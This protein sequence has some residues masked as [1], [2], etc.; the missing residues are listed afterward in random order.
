MK[1]SGALC[2]ALLFVTHPALYRAARVTMARAADAASTAVG[3]HHRLWPSV[4]HSTQVIINRET[5]FHRDTSGKDTWYELLMSLGTCSKAALVLRN[6]GIQVGYLPGTAVLMSSRL[7]HHGV[8]KVE[9][10]RICYT[11]YMS[12]SLHNNFSGE[13]VPWVTR[14]E[15]SG[16]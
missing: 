12:A 16:P 10:D 9:P 3:E 4:W 1:E 15:L 13:D 11:W 6:I 5:P 2:S 14:D 7:I 8:A